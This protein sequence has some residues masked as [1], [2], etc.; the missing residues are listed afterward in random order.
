MV[1][2]VVVVEPLASMVGSQSA[3]QEQNP[4]CCRYRQTKT[5]PPATTCDR[6]AAYGCTWRAGTPDLS[7]GFPRP[8]ERALGHG[9]G[10][11]AS[12]TLVWTEAW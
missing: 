9:G 5:F 6:S 3:K 12:G 4:R 1:V 11:R 8:S 7:C 10:G 2:L